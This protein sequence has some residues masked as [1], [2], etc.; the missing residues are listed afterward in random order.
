MLVNILN[1]NL[2]LLILS[3]IPGVQP[4]SYKKREITLVNVFIK[5]FKKKTHCPIFT[6]H[7][8]EV[9]ADSTRSSSWFL[10]KKRERMLETFLDF[11][12]LKKKKYESRL[13]CYTYHIIS[14]SLQAGSY[15][16]KIMKFLFI[17]IKQITKKKISYLSPTRPDSK[18]KSLKK[19]RDETLKNIS[20]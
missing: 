20:L 2:S 3:T 1:I 7:N 18:N 17:L 13:S 14:R 6:A 9:R 8:P 16:D 11:F 19:G 15:N 10:Q 5:I 4:D 12:F